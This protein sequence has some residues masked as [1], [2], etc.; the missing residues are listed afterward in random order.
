MVYRATK[1]FLKFF[2]QQKEERIF[3]NKGS[4]RNLWD[5]M[6]HNNICIIGVPK[7]EEWE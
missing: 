5:N 2:K 7:Q 4:L 1:K 6:K 3:K